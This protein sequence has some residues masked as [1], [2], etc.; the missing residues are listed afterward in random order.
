MAHPWIPNSADDVKR[1]M[2]KLIGI[3][4]IEELYA[5]IPENVRFPAEKWDALPIGQGRML[6]EQE[7][8][9]HMDSL[10]ARIAELKAP[11]FMGGGV[12]PRYVPEA[13]KSVITR[14]ELMTAYTPYQAE[15]S[16]G[17][18]QVL[19]EYQSLMAELLEMELVNSSMYDG[20][21]ALA[22]AF[23][24]AMRVTGRKRFLVPET[25]NPLYRKVVD[26]Y[27]SPHGASV[28]EVKV[29]RE[30]G[31]LNLEDLQ[32][33]A[34]SDVA[35]IYMEY[36][37]Y[38]GIIDEGAQDAG[39]IAHRAG[40]LYVMGVE[41]VS[42]SIL[43]PPGALGADIAVAEGQSLGLGLNFGGPYL[44]VFAVRWDRE[45]VKQMPGRI[46]GLTSSIDGEEA[47]TLVLQTR[48]QHIRRAKATS[49]ITTNEAL[50]AI[51]A[52]AYVLLLGRSGLEELA[53]HCWYK[54]HYAARKLSQF[55]RSPLLSGEFIYEF[56]VRLPRNAREVRR[57]LLK[58]GILAGIPLEGHAWFSGNDLLLA[59]TE[60]H[61]KDDIELLASSM[62]EVM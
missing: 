1:E 23:L 46:V 30:T 32:A 59:V 56:V 7:L 48:E 47:F 3:S 14:G 53:K 35:A 60:V 26:T 11:P 36:P 39:E 6:S 31:Q 22:E 61:S 16:Q 8:K 49:N 21:S 58:R 5:D 52:S 9:R 37:H 17:L 4:K 51:A 54:S 15:I 33:K 43:K 50:M 34:R 44:G 41:P 62:M 45:L 12:L 25:M 55:A 24:M 20:S 28:Q 10:F 38:T 29:D 2:M 40:A 18:L 13:V 19:F 27:L 42:L 57:E